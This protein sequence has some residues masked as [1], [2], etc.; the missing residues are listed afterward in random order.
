MNQYIKE[1]WKENG[2]QLI[3]DKCEIDGERVVGVKHD[4]KNYIF[5]IIPVYI[6]STKQYI[7]NNSFL[8]EDEML[9]FIKLKAFL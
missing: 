1:F 8:S 3:E 5:Y 2:Y 7:Y 6:Y 4:I 9:R